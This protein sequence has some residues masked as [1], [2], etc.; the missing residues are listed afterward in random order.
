MVKY[1]QYHKKNKSVLNC[2]KVLV[3]ERVQEKSNDLFSY[4]IKILNIYI[5]FEE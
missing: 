4:V 1:E 3:L 5:E 2:V